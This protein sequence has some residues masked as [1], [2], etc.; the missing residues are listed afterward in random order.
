LPT[1]HH[2]QSMPFTYDDTIWLGPVR[3]C[4]KGVDAKDAW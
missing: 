3:V 4:L 1:A 2:S